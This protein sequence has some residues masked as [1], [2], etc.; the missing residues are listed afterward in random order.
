MELWKLPLLPVLHSAQ[1]PSK[2]SH[3][4]VAYTVYVHVPSFSAGQDN[5]VVLYTTEE[6]SRVS[7]QPLYI[8]LCVGLV[9]S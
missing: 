7:L 3:S 2:S 6:N 9:H 1:V 8:V 5:L 4:T